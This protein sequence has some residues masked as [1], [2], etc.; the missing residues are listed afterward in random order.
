MYKNILIATDG[1]EL[2]ENAVR[3]GVDLA[4]AIGA[5][6][7]G[8]TVTIPL[9]TYVSNEVAATIDPGIFEERTARMAEQ[10]L[11]P[12]AEQAT[13]AGVECETMR[14]QN[15]AVYEGI[16]DAA[17]KKRCDLIV[18]ASHGRRGLSG[19]ILGSETTKVLTHSKI[20]VLVCR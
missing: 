14:V 8:I 19:F 20:P 17:D 12:V 18:M 15:V 3:H 9:E 13:Q 2:S 7:T 6:V 1:S 10:S 11:A 16:I 5:R 4:K